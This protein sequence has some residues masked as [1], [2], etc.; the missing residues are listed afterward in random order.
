LKR[1]VVSYRF[2]YVKVPAVCARSVHFRMVSMSTSAATVEPFN[3]VGFP[4]R[5][6][7]SYGIFLWEKNFRPSQPCQ[8]DVFSNSPF[9]I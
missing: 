2:A 5:A 7:L 3:P 8:L 1:E 4:V 6:L 9:E